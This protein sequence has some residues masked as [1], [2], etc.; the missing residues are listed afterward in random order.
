MFIIIVQNNDGWTTDYTFSFA[1]SLPLSRSLSLSCFNL[2]FLLALHFIYLSTSHFIS[3]DV[4]QFYQIILAMELSERSNFLLLFS[5]SISNIV[6]AYM[7]IYHLCHLYFGLHSTLV[8]SLFYY[9]TNTYRFKCK[10]PNARLDIGWFV[11]FQQFNILTVLQFICKK[12]ECFFLLGQIVE[13]IWRKKYKT[14][15]GFIGFGL[16]LIFFHHWT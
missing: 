15:I 7:R 12:K 9:Q 4:L 3:S 5:F 14:V 13:E 8:R 11:F 10:Q 16:L 6:D 1:L 2:T